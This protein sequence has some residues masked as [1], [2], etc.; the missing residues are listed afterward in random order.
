[1]GGTPHGGKGDRTI[2]VV[3]DGSGGAEEVAISAADA[4]RYAQAMQNGKTADEALRLIG[5]LE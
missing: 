5:V 2:A 3:P 4:R 1:V